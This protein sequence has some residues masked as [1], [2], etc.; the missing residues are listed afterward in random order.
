MI[1]GLKKFSAVCALM[2][3]A[4][5]SGLHNSATASVNDHSQLIAEGRV[6][7]SKETTVF[8]PILPKLKQ[9]TQ[10]PIVLPKIIPSA[11][12]EKPLYA[13]IEN[14]TPKKYDILLGFSPNCNG[15][16]GCR[17]G[18]VTAEA[19]TNKTPKLT[20][21]TVSLAKGII[22]YFVDSA[23]GANCSDATL[24]WRQKGVQ[25]VIG[26]KAGDRT[27]LIKMANSAINP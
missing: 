21:K 8:K 17:F 10:L 1:F 9:K 2:L 14:A 27:S 11:E 25:Y 12:G 4:S 19:V 22:G 20:G 16:T 26:L 5:A 24:T 15:G 6:S 3:V 23:C 13:I 18:I 7:T